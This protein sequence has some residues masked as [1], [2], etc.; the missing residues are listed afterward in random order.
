MDTP[1]LRIVHVVS[2]LQGGG[3]EHFVLRLAES[4]QSRG[5]EVSVVAITPGPLL[6]IAAQKHVVT[7]VL[8]GPTKGRRILDAVAY[9]ALR[10]PHLVHCHNPT[11]LHYATIA[12]LAGRARLVFTDHA[13]TKGIVRVGSALEWRLVDAY[14]SVSA[15][16]ARHA[17]DIGYP[18]VPEVVHNGIDFTPA[19]RKRAELRAELGLGDRVVGVN[20]A[21]FFPVKA[22]D[23]LVRAAGVLKERGVPV[24]VLCVGDG[25]ERQSVEKLAAG[26]LLPA[27]TAAPAGQGCRRSRPQ[28]AA[29]RQMAVCW[30]VAT[31]SGPAIHSTSRRT[32][33]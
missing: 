1:K 25:V 22:Q 28:V 9:F 2:S 12:K 10:R 11:S 7:K 6:D 4:Q 15:E 27:S 31:G 13:Q 21:S 16:T 14:A 32:K 3:M 19:L 17:G 24:T 18:G 26:L 23:V 30:A 5:H 33:R 8:R 29:S 20:V